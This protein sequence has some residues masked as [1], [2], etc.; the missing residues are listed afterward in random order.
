M[1]NTLTPEQ[2]AAV[3][4]VSLAPESAQPIADILGT[5]GLRR[6]KST[7]DGLSHVPR[8][9]LLSAFA[10][11]LTELNDRIGGLQ[12]GKGRAHSL[13]A[14]ALGPELAGSIAAPLEIDF[15]LMS[16]APQTIWDQFAN[17]E[18][19]A[20]AAFI[21]DQ[22]APLA[23]LM[24]SQLPPPKMA[25]IL[26]ELEETLSVDVIACLAKDSQPSAIALQTAETMVE[27]Y[28]LNGATDLSKDPRLEE[29]G[30]ILGSLPRSLRD[31]A[32]EKLDATDVDRAA[33][34]RKALLSLEDIPERLPT[35]GVQ[36]IFREVNPDILLAGLAAASAEVPE[37]SDF[38]LGNISQ[39]MAEQ[40]RESMAALNL[41]TQSDR[42]KAIG[43]LLREILSLSRSGQITLLERPSKED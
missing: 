30:E 8:K 11:F 17:T 7:L 27:A 19:S 13:L 23:A 42:D 14:S 5:E 24:V 3:V 18:T 12:G 10:V 40:Y 25:E 35:R 22:A 28:L 41:E 20:L 33:A 15:P 31:A 26:S 36:T 6:V 21:G 38:L 2:Q 1:N 32:L 34:V 29:V 43:A 16:A 39:R 4:L 9:E 37:A